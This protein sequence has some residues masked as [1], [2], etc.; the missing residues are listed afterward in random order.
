MPS[1]YL[2]HNSDDFKDY[3]ATELA[4]EKQIKKSSKSDDKNRAEELAKVAFKKSS[5]NNDKKFLIFKCKFCERSYSEGLM[6]Q[7]HLSEV[8]NVSGPDAFDVHQKVSNQEFLDSIGIGPSVSNANKVENQIFSKE[9]NSIGI[10]PTIIK[11]NVTNHEAV[12]EVVSKII[13]GSEMNKH[14][15]DVKQESIDVNPWNITSL[16]DLQ[17]FICPSCDFQNSSKQTFVCHAFASH[18]EAVDFLKNIS[19]GSLDNVLCPWNSQEGIMGNS[20]TMDTPDITWSYEGTSNFKT[21]KE[22]ASDDDDIDQDDPLKANSENEDT[23]FNEINSETIKMEVVDNLYH[24]AVME[25]NENEETPKLPHKCQYCGKCFANNGKLDLHVDIFHEFKCE[26]CNEFFFME[27]ALNVHMNSVHEGQKNYKCDYCEK[28]FGSKQVLEKHT[29]NIHG[30]VIRCYI[31]ETTLESGELCGKKFS[32]DFDLKRHISGHENKC[33]QCGQEFKHARNLKR[34]LETVHEGR[35]DY[36]CNSC[37]KSYGSKQEL[38]RHTHN[39]HE[40]HENC[41]KWCENR[42]KRLEDFICDSCGS[43]YSGALAL[44]KHIL[45]VHDGQMPPKDHKCENCGKAFASKERLSVH[46]L[47][48]SISMINLLKFNFTQCS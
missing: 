45:E 42:K 25:R 36:K 12:D 27:S 38:D 2:D 34:H 7:K 48:V 37:E 24:S 19:D 40:G 8:H 22:K 26:L 35:R 13:A 46:V 16:H 29:L 44:D 31:C 3:R 43:S 32:T 41:P 1:L 14:N 10:P 28:S 20:N 39:F 4:K 11:V 21:S 47:G 15:L 18:P 9:Q 17:Y 23:S 30:Q 5:K 33:P 6:F